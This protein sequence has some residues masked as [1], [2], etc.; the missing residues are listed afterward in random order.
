M[1]GRAMEKSV[2]LRSLG[3]LHMRTGDVKMGRYIMHNRCPLTN[4]KL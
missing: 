1:K 3:M 2:L 4:C